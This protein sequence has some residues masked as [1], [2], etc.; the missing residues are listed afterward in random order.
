[1]GQEAQVRTSTSSFPTKHPMSATGSASHSTSRKRSAPL[2]DQDTRS[3]RNRRDNDDDEIPWWEQERSR[4]S[5]APGTSASG[6][7]RERDW[8]QRSPHGR[9]RDW[10]NSRRDRGGGGGGGYRGRERDSYNP[11]QPRTTERY[12]NRERSPSSLQLNYGAPPLPPPTAPRGG[13]PAGRGRGRGDSA[14]YRQRNDY[15]AGDDGRRGYGREEYSSTTTTAEQRGA[16]PTPLNGQ[17]ET[18][19]DLLD[20]R[21]DDVSQPLNRGYNE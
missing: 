15:R 8:D 3:P 12:S 1:M 16:L 5:M 19:A 10:D 17:S 14:G 18:R 20:R 11:R 4:A 13:G 6:R 21:R 7:E 2:S 9:N